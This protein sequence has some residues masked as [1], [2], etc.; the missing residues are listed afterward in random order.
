MKIIIIL[1]FVFVSIWARPY[2]FI[3][4]KY[5]KELELEAKIIAK[6]AKLSSSDKITLFIPNMTLKEE[7]IY[8]RYITVSQTC[9]ASNF[10]F[11][12]KNLNLNELCDTKDKLFF[13][14]N[15]QR[16]LADKTYYGAF[17]WS[18]SRPN[19]VFIK[20]RLEKKNILLPE[21]FSSYIEDF[22]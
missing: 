9:E 7:V 17:F 10:V 16:L 8:S 5:D 14:N 3:V 11:V 22:R 21:D 12:K 2:T 15:Y 18:K 20:N 6:I 4:E 13:T 19:I 1:S